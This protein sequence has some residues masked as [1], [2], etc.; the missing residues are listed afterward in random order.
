[1]ANYLTTD[2][3]LTSIANAI[4]TKGG[5]QA[6]LTYPTGFVSAIND[7]PTGGGK[8]SVVLSYNQEY[9]FR[10]QTGADLIAAVDFTTSNLSSIQYMFEGY[11]GT[12]IPFSLNIGSLNGVQYL[13]SKCYYLTTLPTINFNSSG[14]AANG[15][16]VYMFDHCEKITTIPDG[17][18]STYDFTANH[19]S[20]GQM[21]QYMFNCCFSLTHIDSG[22]L[23]NLYSSRTNANAW[24][25]LF[26]SC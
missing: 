24:Q 8:P 22:L 2:T 13:F 18:F 11:T 17:Y 14:L 19:S 23:P 1:M 6:Q 7:I 10:G 5:T 12:T 9:R 26:S 20:T 15:G 25:Y 21:G 4:R 16:L 3:E